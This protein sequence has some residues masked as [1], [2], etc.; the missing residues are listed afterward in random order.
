ML[1][2]KNRP[3][4]N[5]IFISHANPEDNAFARWLGA[6]LTAMGYEVWADV[7]RIPG[8]ADWSRELEMALRNRTRKMLL[9]ANPLSVDRQGVRNEITIA[10]EVAKK[11][12]DPAFIIPLR[13]APFSAPFLV[14]Q[15]QYIDFASWATGFAELNQTLRDVYKIPRAAIGNMQPWFDAQALGAKKLMRGSEPLISNW[16]PIAKV[17]EFVTMLKARS[18]F[19]LEHF[20]DKGRY[21]F[22]VVPFGESIVTFA[23]EKSV[24]PDI[25]V[26]EASKTLLRDFLEYGWPQQGIDAFEARRMFAELANQAVAGWLSQRGLAG[27]VAGKR[28]VWWPNIRTAPLTQVSFKWA[29]GPGGRRQ[30]VGQSEKRGVHWHFAIDT[31]VRSAPILHIRIFPKLIFSDNGMEPL[32]DAKRMHKLRRS[33][34]KWRNA[35]WRD[36]LLAFLWWLGDGGAEL[37]VVV[38]PGQFMR[39]QLPPLTL[40]STHRV[41]HDGVDAEDE[42]DPEVEGA[43]YGDENIDV[44]DEGEPE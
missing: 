30:I 18:G 3:P 37:A 5:A 14:A 8:G 40:R 13:L 43:E 4:R 24:S 15:A 9:V 27:Y 23:D 11:L 33:F 42:D 20:H 12:G 22:P 25:A 44:E 1:G 28:V 29:D 31:A 41:F 19:P 34:A 32:K 38:A 6:K 17:P 7:M 21:A 35:R 10:S 39:V 2:S 16:L 26:G 36:M